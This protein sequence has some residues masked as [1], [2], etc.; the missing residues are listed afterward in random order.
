MGSPPSGSS[1]ATGSSIDTSQAEDR[2]RDICRFAGQLLFVRQI[3]HEEM[4]ARMGEAKIINV[5]YA[6]PQADLGADRIKIRVERLLRQQKISEPH[7]NH[8]VLAPDKQR[9]RLF[10]GDD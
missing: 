8:T 4:A 7:R 2:D 9:Q 6:Q 1:F 10:Q 5:Q 3:S